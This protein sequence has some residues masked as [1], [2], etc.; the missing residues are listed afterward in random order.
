MVTCDIEVRASGE[1]TQRSAQ[2]QLIGNL[3][4]KRTPS[5]ARWLLQVG[6][7]HVKQEVEGGSARAVFA[8]KV[9]LRQPGHLRE[10]LGAAAQV[11]LLSL[12]LRM[13]SK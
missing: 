11:R 8:T 4:A 5:A 12:I 3:S 13:R 9:A 2:Q 10:T 6:F 1:E 7:D